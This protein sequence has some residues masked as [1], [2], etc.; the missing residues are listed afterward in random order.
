MVRSRCRASAFVLACWTSTQVTRWTWV[1]GA[2]RLCQCSVSGLGGLAMA[3][4]RNSVIKTGAASVEEM[5]RILNQTSSEVPDELD[6]LFRAAIDQVS[7]QQYN[8]SIALTGLAEDG[9][10]AQA[11]ATIKNAIAEAQRSALRA[12]REYADLEGKL[13]KQ[14][15]IELGKIPANV[16]DHYVGK[17][18]LDRRLVES[19]SLH[20]RNDLRALEPLVAVATDYRDWRAK[21]NA[22]SVGTRGITANERRRVWLQAIAIAIAILLGIFNL[23]K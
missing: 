10:A 1:D 16:T 21:V 13:A 22:T 15:E 23:I 8:V 7:D 18:T 6:S 9:D 5:R 17:Q 19:A 3:I 4:E 2:G 14:V 20:E 11:E 12:C